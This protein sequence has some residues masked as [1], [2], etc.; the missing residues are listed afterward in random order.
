MILEATHQDFISILSNNDEAIFFFH[1]EKDKQSAE[2][3][4]IKTSIKQIIDEGM[5]VN[6]HLFVTDATPEQ[7]AFS[8]V[9]ELDG[10]P[11]IVVYKNGSFKRYKNKDF[12]K[13]KLKKFLTPSKNVSHQNNKVEE[14]YEI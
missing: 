3:K 2:V 14:T 12:A 6:V 8:D 4:K 1:Q 5:K 11:T 9:L 10:I 7:E 13:D